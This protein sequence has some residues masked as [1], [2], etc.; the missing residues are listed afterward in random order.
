MGK[1]QQC[2]QG[3]EAKLQ[4][5][6]LAQKQD[7]HLPHHHHLREMTSAPR[8]TRTGRCRRT[9]FVAQKLFAVFAC[10]RGYFASEYPLA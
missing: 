8:P 9:R 7:L 10:R 6:R 3:I 5:V 2:S 1:T 4:F